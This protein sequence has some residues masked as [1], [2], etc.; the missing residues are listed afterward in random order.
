MVLQNIQ[1]HEHSFSVEYVEDVEASGWC[2]YPSWPAGSFSAPTYSNGSGSSF[3]GLAEVQQ[4][5]FCTKEHDG[6]PRKIME[7]PTDWS[8]DFS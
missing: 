7:K 5:P 8:T 4:N 3:D 1:N 6:K 2:T